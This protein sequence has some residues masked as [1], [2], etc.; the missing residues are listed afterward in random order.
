ML[1]IRLLLGKGDN[2]DFLFRFLFSFPLIKKKSCKNHIFILL[3]S[4]SKQTDTSYLQST[5]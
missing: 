5:F 4:R 3:L 1:I 2:F